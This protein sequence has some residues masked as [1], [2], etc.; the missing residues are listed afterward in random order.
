MKKALIGLLVA[1][2]AVLATG[3]LL[4][5]LFPG[6]L[7]KTIALAAR[8]SA[9]VSRHEVQV[10]EYRWVYLDGGKGDVIVFIHGYGANKDF[11]GDLVK[12]VSGNHRVIVPDLPGWGENTRILSDNYGVPAQAKR[13]HRF[14]EKL[15]L[16]RFHL[17]GHSMGGAIAAWYAGEHPERLKSLLL[18]DPFGVRNRTQAEWE[19]EYARDRTEALYVKTEKGFL[20]VYDLAFDNPPRLPGRFLDFLVEECRKEYGIQKKIFEDLYGGGQGVLEDRL[21]KITAPTLII[22]GKN[23]RIFPVS[24]AE[25]FRQGVRNS[26]LEI[27]DGGH[28]I[29]MDQPV[30]TADLYRDFLKG[31]E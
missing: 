5:F 3:A 24:S 18:M 23:D 2:G 28:T 10:D 30:I 9:G 16:A 8:W 29:F 27:I 4:Y 14:A 12:S 7:L 17:V 25:V 15:G 22:W 1:I 19:P 13:L 6:T 31:L 20:R 26:R 21:G 11:W